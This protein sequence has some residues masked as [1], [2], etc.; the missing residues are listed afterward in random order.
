[1]ST[2][3]KILIVDDEPL[4]RR[5]LALILQGKGYQVT[6]AA[7]AQEGLQAI[8][9]DRMDLVFLDI[10]L[11]DRSGVTLLPEI[12]HL[13]PDLPVLFLTAHATLETAVDAVNLGAR[14]YLL[15]PIDPGNILFRIEEILSE[16][17]QEKRRG[18][19]TA[20]IQALASELLQQ[21]T[22][23]E[24]PPAQP[25]PVEM[26]VSRY[27]Q[28]GPIT[29]DLHT[30]QV[31][32]SGRSIS[33]RPTTFDYLVTLVRHTPNPVSYQTMVKEAQG[34]EMTRA[35]AREVTRWHIHELRKALDED[36]HVPRYIFTVRDVGYRFVI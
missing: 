3:T 29:L 34:Y 23:E 7:N 16:Q 6:T 25:A 4:L 1:M 21:A 28:V 36:T 24:V 19:I 20:Q 9:K 18:E 14:G 30:N 17:K 13:Y 26:D 35:E 11:P 15:K 5:S 33:L 22:Q 10:N 27:L 8:Q 12:R 31:L 2:P 32:L